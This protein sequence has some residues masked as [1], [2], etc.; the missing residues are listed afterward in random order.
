MRTTLDLPEALVD[1]AMK[2]TQIKTKTNV[3]IAALEDLIRKSKISGLKAYKG[4]V[5]LDID[6]NAVR[7]RQCRY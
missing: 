1:E 7:G 5:D 6:M 4:K 2:V 3:I